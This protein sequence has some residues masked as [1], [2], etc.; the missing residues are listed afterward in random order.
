MNDILEELWS[1]ADECREWARGD[2]DDRDVKAA[3][4][5]AEFNRLARRLDAIAKDLG[6]RLPT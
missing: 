1:L 5:R 3:A 6:A 2:I 4:V